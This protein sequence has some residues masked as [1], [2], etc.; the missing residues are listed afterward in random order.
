MEKQ[1]NRKKK[2]HKCNICNITDLSQGGVLFQKQLQKH[3]ISG[4][5]GLFYM[6]HNFP[7]RRNWSGFLWVNISCCYYA[8]GAYQGVAMELLGCCGF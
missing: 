4:P 7:I 3:V 2:N 6:P 5:F 8:M 1:I